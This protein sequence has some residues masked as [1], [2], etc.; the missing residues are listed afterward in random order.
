MMTNVLD[1]ETFKYK[2]L[3]NKYTKDLTEEEIKKKYEE[4]LKRF[5]ITHS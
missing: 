4:Y 2:L 5:D 1:Y 3:T